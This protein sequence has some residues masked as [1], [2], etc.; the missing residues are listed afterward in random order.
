M[1]FNVVARNQDGHVKNIAFL[2]DKAGN[3]SLSPAYDVT[4]SFNPTGGA[5]G[6]FP[7]IIC[8][9]AQT[10]PSSN[11][12]DGDSVKIQLS[13]VPI[14]GE[15][16]PFAQPGRGQTRAIA[17]PQTQRLRRGTILAA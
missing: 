4:Y 7:R 15:H 5:G 2:M 14:C 11:E 8:C 12:A 10:S 9:R 16:G 3:W 17:E 6:C 1:V 13:P